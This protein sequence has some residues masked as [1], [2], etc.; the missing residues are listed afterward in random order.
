M[1][2]SSARAGALPA[3]L[4]RPLRHRAAIF[5]LK[6]RA[7]ASAMVIMPYARPPQ[8]G[9]GSFDAARSA[10]CHR[11]LG[12]GYQG[13]SE[14]SRKMT[15]AMFAPEQF[16]DLSRTEHRVIFENVEA[17]LAEPCRRSRLICSFGSSP[18]STGKLIGK[19]FISHTVFV[20]KGTV[21]EHGRDNQGTG[22]DRREL[23]RIASAATSAKTSSS[24][25]ASWRGNSC[26]FK[27]T[28]DL[29]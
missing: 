7:P 28:L 23:P 17:C 8:Q 1:R 25:T 20:G 29:R 2:A 14:S 3:G 6:R 27:N 10:S 22:L 16:L 4:A 18:R 5:S 9:M 11:L 13:R 26:E 15:R 12:E 19:P 24:A 21:I